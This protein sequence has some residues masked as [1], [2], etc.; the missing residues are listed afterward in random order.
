VAASVALGL[1]ERRRRR[2]AADG[3][4]VTRRRWILAV[5]LLL[6]VALLPVG[7]HSLR[8]ARDTV[9]ATPFSLAFPVAPAAPTAPS[10]PSVGKA[11]GSTG[12]ITNIYPY[13]RDGRLLHDVLLFD[14][15]GQPLSLMPGDTDP[16]RRVLTGP[17]GV[18]IF[19]SYPLRYFDP[20]TTRVGNP[21]A[22]PALAPPSLFTPAPAAAVA[23]HRPAAA[24]AKPRRRGH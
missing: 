17:G 22:A 19:N 2:A 9:T 15:D 16:T 5:N 12:L 3:A 11:L 13:T 14:Q 21:N 4:E 8:A 23:P 20:G 24:A 7:V 6:A 18:R 1:G 10:P